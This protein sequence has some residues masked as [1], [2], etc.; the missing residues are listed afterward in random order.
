[1]LTDLP[2]ALPLLKL[3]IE[4]NKSNWQNS[5][6]NA[7]AAS[8]NWSE[9]VEIN[10]VPDLILLADCVYYKKVLN[11]NSLKNLIV[12]AIFQSV[13]CLV[14]TLKDL[15]T[16]QTKIFL[17]QEVRDSK[18]QRECWESFERQIGEFFTLYD[19]PLSEQ[20]AEYSS[21]DIVLIRLSKL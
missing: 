10:F 21:P 3:N 2:E 11:K 1:M 9:N 12:S 17:S 14:E 16:P 19:I 20:N 13:G 4:N 7:E 15:A 18:K 8:L 5:K 6:G